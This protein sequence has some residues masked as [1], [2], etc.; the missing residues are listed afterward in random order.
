VKSSQLPMPAGSGRAVPVASNTS[1]SLQPARRRT[2]RVLWMR[3]GPMRK[4]K[5]RAAL[6]ATAGD[7]MAIRW[8]VVMALLW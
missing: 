1:Q 6:G 2:K 3:Q 5:S 4:S 8:G 7:G